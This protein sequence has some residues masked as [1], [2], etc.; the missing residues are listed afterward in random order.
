MGFALPPIEV[1]IICNSLVRV[2]KS[3]NEVASASMLTRLAPHFHTLARLI[4][5]LARFNAGLQSRLAHKLDT[6][7]T[8]IEKRYER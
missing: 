7:L 6:Y 1:F 8:E 5:H 3:D 2:Y 4:I